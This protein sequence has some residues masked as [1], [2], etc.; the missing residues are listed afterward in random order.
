MK[1]EP[2]PDGAMENA[3]AKFPRYDQVLSYKQAGKE[4]NKLEPNPQLL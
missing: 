1:I 3:G 4:S 2:D